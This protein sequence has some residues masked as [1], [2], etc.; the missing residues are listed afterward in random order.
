MNVLLDTSVWS[1]AL[2]RKDP[3]DGSEEQELRELVREGRI[4]VMGAIRQEI[5]SG[6]RAKPQF[7]RIR[8]QLRAFDDILLGYE[9]HEEAAS[10]FNRCREV[11]IQGGSIDF[12]ICAVALRRKLPVFTRD[13]DFERY[14]T[15]LPLKL[16]RVRAGL[17]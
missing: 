16:H 10:C 6:I 4:V 14:A 2:R 3:K 15:V 8:R 12:L 17:P 9:D 5:L 13:R 11:G 1:L 7:E